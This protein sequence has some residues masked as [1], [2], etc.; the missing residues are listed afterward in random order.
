MPLKMCKLQPERVKS[1][2]FL[3]KDVIPN[4][5]TNVPATKDVIKPKPCYTVIQSCAA[6]HLVKIKDTHKPC[7]YEE[8]WEVSKAPIATTMEY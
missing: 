3:L 5:C 4:H 1:K 2:T 7:L 6:Q 8:F